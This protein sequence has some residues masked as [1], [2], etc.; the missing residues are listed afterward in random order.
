[1]VD[2][3]DFEAAKERRTIAEIDETIR[4]LAVFH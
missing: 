4:V 1:M 3:I 2:L